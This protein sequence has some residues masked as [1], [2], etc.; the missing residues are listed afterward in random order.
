MGER[1]AA[2]T[3]LREVHVAHGETVAAPLQADLGE[4]AAP[5]G[6]N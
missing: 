1:F 2:F 4:A 3:G 6:C 5:A